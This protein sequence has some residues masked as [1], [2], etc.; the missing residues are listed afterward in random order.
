MLGKGKNLIPRVT[1]LLDSTV[2]CLTKNHKAYKETGKYGPNK[3]KKSTETFPEKNIMADIL[4]KEFKTTVLKMPREQKECVEKVKKTVCE[5]NGNINKGI[6][7][8]KETKKK[9]WR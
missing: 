9:F 6:E 8:L 7:N 1:T 4:D 2:Q 3:Q 5:Q